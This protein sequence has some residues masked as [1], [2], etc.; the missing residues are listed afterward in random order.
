MGRGGL[1]FVIVVI[2]VVIVLLLIVALD[3]FLLIILIYFIAVISTIIAI[4]NTSRNDDN[5]EIIKYI[6]IFSYSV[7]NIH[8][9]LSL[10]CLFFLAWILKIRENSPHD[11]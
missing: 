2:E 7:T 10:A 1:G 9:M 4:M 3:I 8:L 11:Q 5:S 6:F